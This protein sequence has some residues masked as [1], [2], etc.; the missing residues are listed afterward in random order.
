M[1][2]CPK[3]ILSGKD[4]VTSA[5]VH[6]LKKACE[7][8]GDTLCMFWKNTLLTLGKFEKTYILQIMYHRLRHSKLQCQKEKKAYLHL[9]TDTMDNIL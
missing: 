7:P 4:N 3:Y 2:S 8:F 9:W 1:T 5:V 6:K